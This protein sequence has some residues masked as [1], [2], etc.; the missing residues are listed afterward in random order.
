M[1]TKADL[2]ARVKLLRK[3]KGASQQQVADDLEI[4]KSTYASYEAGNL[5]VDVAVRL[6]EYFGVTF[7]E[8]FTGRKLQTE[9]QIS[10]DEQ[11]LL[12]AYR[13]STPIG[14]RDILRAALRAQNEARHS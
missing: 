6:V 2:A 1:I 13:E 11:D 3:E 10:A 9:E 7:D 14:Q 4:S 5:T 8:F 12:Q